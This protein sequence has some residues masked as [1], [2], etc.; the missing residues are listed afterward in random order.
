MLKSKR[1]LGGCIFGGEDIDLGSR[2]SISDF[3]Q[4][5]QSLREVMQC[6]DE[7]ERDGMSFR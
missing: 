5:T 6:V 3:I 2:V 1:L 4:Q 7:D